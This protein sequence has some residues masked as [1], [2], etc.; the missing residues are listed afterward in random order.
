MQMMTRTRIATLM[1]VAGVAASQLMAQ[2]E[3][4]KAPEAPKLPDVPKFEVPKVEVPKVEVPKAPKVVKPMI[5]GDLVAMAAL[6]ESTE[7]TAV[8]T[9][10][11][12]TEG[13]LWH[14][15]ALYFTD[16][17]KDSVYKT[18][19]GTTPV[20]APVVIKE[21]LGTP[22]GLAVDAKGVMYVSTFRKGVNTLAEDGTVTL[23]ADKFEDKSFN[24]TNDIVIAVD[25][26]QYFTD[27]GFTGRSQLQQSGVYRRAVD[28]KITPV[29]TDF[30][31][32]NGLAFSVDRKQLYVTEYNPDIRNIRVFDVK[33]DGSLANGRV[34]ATVDEERSV[35]DGVKVDV[36]GNVYVAAA[37]GVVIFDSAG[38]RIGKINAGPT[39]NLCFGGEDGKTLFLT[40]SGGV[41]SVKMKVAGA[42][43]ANSAK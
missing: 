28:G 22:A 29:V 37:G 5:E 26:S 42:N 21:K 39:S 31:Q 33:A 14:N 27:F 16:M 35:P 2:P 38:K 15:G 30:K 8:A 36:N 41:K 6:V 9:G 17:A 25:G 43:L 12:R 10:M 24:G 19:P 7:L 3:M 34:F 23:V 13:P 20:D 32:A 40:G 18:I 1:I 4:P 11:A